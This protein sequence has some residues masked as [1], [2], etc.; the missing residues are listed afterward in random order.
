M[1]HPCSSRLYC[2][3]VSVYFCSPAP[4]VFNYRLF[5][6]TLLWKRA[7]HTPVVP[8]LT[9]VS[10]R[11]HLM[12]FCYTVR[13]SALKSSCLPYGQ[14][15]YNLEYSKRVGECESLCYVRL[16]SAKEHY[17][18]RPLCLHACVCAVQVHEHQMYLFIMS[19]R[20]SSSSCRS[21]NLNP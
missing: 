12:F 13:S 16:N 5:L 14:C 19:R 10:H 1:M 6:Y 20:E 4:W 2:L 15:H 9:T 8:S 18:V 17:A 11:H 7:V 21:S 3:P